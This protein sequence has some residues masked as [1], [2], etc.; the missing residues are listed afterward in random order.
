MAVFLLSHCF[1]TWWG[2]RVEVVATLQLPEIECVRDR[3][4]VSSLLCWCKHTCVFDRH[5]WVFISSLSRVMI[6]IR[7]CHIE[8]LSK[9]IGQIQGSGLY[10][11]HLSDQAPSFR[12][13]CESVK[14]WNYKI[15]LFF[16]HSLPAVLW[17]ICMVFFLPGRF[18]TWLYTGCPVKCH[19]C[20]WLLCGT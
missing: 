1:H 20:P 18:N 8:K 17:L 15:K 9:P 6:Q 12:R 3:V 19:P 7:V 10:S 5:T 11:L 2:A 4:P 13:F 16:G 14:L